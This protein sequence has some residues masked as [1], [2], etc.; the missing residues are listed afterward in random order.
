[1]SRC[2]NGTILVA[3]SLAV[4]A[5]LT[6]P[7]A[8]AS[9]QKKKSAA[10]KLPPIYDPKVDGAQ[11]ITEA[12]ARAEQDNKRVLLQFGANWCIWCHRLHE[13]FTNDRDIARK[14]LYEYELVLI[15]VAEIDG[16]R[17][18]DDID[19]R[20][21]RPTRGGLPVLVVLDADGKRITTRTTEV[22]EEGDHHDPAKVLAFLEK[23]Q[24][25][26]QSAKETLARAMEQAQS[27]SKNV[28]VYFS[29]PWCRYCKRLTEYLQGEDIAKVF[30]SAYVSVKIDV[31][32]MTG[33]KEIQTRHGATEEDGIPF[34][35]VLSHEGK[36][37]ADSRGVKGN[38]GFPVEP[39]EIR[40][41]MKAIGSSTDRLTA[42]QLVT[43]EDGLTSKP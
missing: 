2:F 37:L 25:Q 18:N 14:L 3:A 12:L 27:Q 21:G 5:A 36:R 31:D 32:R 7:A 19:A 41:F 34:F 22:L 8:S 38:V 39:F 20:Y 33:A 1:M 4:M 11:Q 43:L 6:S 9:V 26:P 30:N 40:H 23:W 28:F 24:P 42:A 16:K 17:H 15:D 29:A 13:L 35:L 10:S